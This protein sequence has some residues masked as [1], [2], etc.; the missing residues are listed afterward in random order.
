MSKAKVVQWLSE[1]LYQS[2]D[3]IPQTAQADPG[4]NIGANA[5]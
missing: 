1:F 5:R 3:V 4:P 2:L